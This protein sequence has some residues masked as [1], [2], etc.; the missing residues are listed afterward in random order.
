M[1]TKNAVEATPEQIRAFLDSHEDGE[2]VWMLNLLKFK[3]TSTY[4]DGD[5]VD[6]AGLGRGVGGLGLDR[7]RL[8]GRR[9]VPAVETHHHLA[10]ARCNARRGGGAD[11]APLAAV[12]GQRR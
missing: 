3:D 8:W 11:L 2:P 6:G 10:R 7:P 4:R 5:Q 1:A 9:P 12:Y